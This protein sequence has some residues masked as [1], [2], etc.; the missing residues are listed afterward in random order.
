MTNKDKLKNRVTLLI[1]KALL[2][3]TQFFNSPN[4]LYDLQKEYSEKILV[5]ID[6]MQ[7]D[8]CDGCTNRKGCITCENG[9]L[10]ETMQEEP[11]SKCMYS[12]DDFTDEDR[13]A[14]CDG[15]E[16]DCEY[17]KKENP[18]SNGLEN[19]EN[20]SV[21][22]FASR[23]FEVQAT[24]YEEAELKAKEMLAAAPLYDGDIDEWQTFKKD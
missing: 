7:E 23:T 19:N 18:V 22:V 14:L 4:I 16:E 15:C 9:E 8:P 1:G 20:Y 5:A 24:S 3:Y 6:S 21:R 10:M 13:K 12:M 2:E 17:N 11:G